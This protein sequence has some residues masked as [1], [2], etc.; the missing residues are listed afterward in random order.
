MGSIFYYL[1]DDIKSLCSVRA[2][3]KRFRKLIDSYDEL[4][5]KKSHDYIVQNSPTSPR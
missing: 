2:V 3:C 4:L 5:W 1:T